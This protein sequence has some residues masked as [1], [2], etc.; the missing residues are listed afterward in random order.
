MDSYIFCYCKTNRLEN[1]FSFHTTSTEF[2]IDNIGS[3]YNLIDYI[4]NINSTDSRISFAGF[5]GNQIAKVI[6]YVMPSKEIT[7]SDTY[8][9]FVIRN[10]KS[11]VRGIK[12][13]KLD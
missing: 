2:Y 9:T 3:I 5:K 1:I 12:N 6:S 4:N 7:M 8:D 13:A 10:K 11:K